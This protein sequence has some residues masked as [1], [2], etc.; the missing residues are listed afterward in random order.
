[1][2]DCIIIGAGP[3]GMMCAISASQNGNK[4][5]L[6][7]KNNILGKKMRLTGGTRCNI[8]NLKEN[9]Q[10]IQ[11][12]PTKNG[13]FLHSSLNN[14]GPYNIYQFF[15]KLGVK[16]KEED[17]NRIF[18][19]SDKALDF[20]DAMHKE[21]IKLNVE[22]KLNTEVID[23][24]KDNEFIITTTSNIYYARNIVIATGGLSYPHTGSTGFGYEFAEKFNHTVTELFPTESPIISHDDVI[25]SKD[26]Q[27]LSFSNITISLINKNNK[28]IKSITD[29]LII[30]HFGISGPAALKLSQFVY[31]YLKEHDEANIQINFIPNI[32]HDEI[33]NL[34]TTNS[35]KNLKTILRSLLP[36]RFIDFMFRRLEIPNERKNS[37]LTNKI[38]NNI[39]KFVK[40]FTLKVHEIKPITVSFVTGGGVS[41]KEINPKTME[42]K[43]IPGL[44]FVGE[45][46]N[47]HGYTGGYNMTIALSTG[48]TAGININ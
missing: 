34:I 3:S 15:T 37:E 30:T 5:L 26:L 13:R 47:L 39:T 10:F 33:I 19:V 31:H 11:N 32:S 40:S 27:G 35:N 17:N 9:E 28:I 29:D 4:V 16:L 22:I 20:I 12:L 45:V 38:I 8:T 43:L 44:Y 7:E 23:V 21:L 24:K 2:Y 42:S 46:L 6:L 41:L 36:N 25:I 48:Y 1:M 18:P 14:F